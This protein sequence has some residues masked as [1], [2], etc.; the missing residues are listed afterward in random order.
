MEEFSN[1]EELVDPNQVM[2]TEECPS[3]MEVMDSK[4]EMVMKKVILST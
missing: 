3:T 1:M 4:H 2:I